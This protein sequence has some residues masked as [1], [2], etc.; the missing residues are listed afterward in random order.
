M[1]RGPMKSRAPGGCVAAPNETGEQR[2]MQLP[3]PMLH[4]VYALCCFGCSRHVRVTSARE[5]AE[6]MSIPH[7]QA[8]KILQDLAGHRILRAHRG[9]GGGYELGRPLSEITLA[10][11][12]RALRCENP[13]NAIPARTCHAV[14]AATCGAHIG[15][16]RLHIRLWQLLEQETIAGLIATRCNNR[17]LLDPIPLP[18]G[19][20]RGKAAP[21]R[22]ERPLCSRT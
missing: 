21:L 3:K 18:D 22:T 7:D 1:L 13:A 12:A 8:A 19:F 17:G 6:Q 16:Q 11:I 14:P 4:A 20:G 10:D 15:L 5:I 9:R 2:P